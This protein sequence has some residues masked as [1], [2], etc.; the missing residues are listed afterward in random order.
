M[1]TLITELIFF[2]TINKLIK[3]QVSEWK[4][5]YEILD[6]AGNGHVSV[7]EFALGHGV[8]M[9]I[10]GKHFFDGSKKINFEQYCL[11]MMLVAAHGD[12]H[13]VNE[14]SIQNAYGDY[15]KI[16]KPEPNGLI[17]ISD[18]TEKNN[19]FLTNDQ[20]EAIL[21][22]M[23]NALSCD[24]HPGEINY[25]QFKE[26]VESILAFSLMDRDHNSTL[27]RKE[28]KKFLKLMQKNNPSEDEVR[29]FFD[30][31]D[32]NDDGEVSLYE[33]LLTKY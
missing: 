31:H 11:Y 13:G 25:V 18:F 4:L 26:I 33:F 12:C 22:P 23:S 29:T 8:I 21:K 14:N 7:H 16:R 9:S 6:K 2:N 30:S 32:I 3:L 20:F 5:H 1:F 17:K 19:G 27:S 10:I 15:C 28:V 24:F